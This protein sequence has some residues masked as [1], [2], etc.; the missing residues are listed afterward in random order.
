MLV[1]TTLMTMLYV[2]KLPNDRGQG[3]PRVRDGADGLYV[4]AYF[5]IVFTSADIRPRREARGPKRILR[6]KRKGCGN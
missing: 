6:P 1:A 3:V 2:S 5:G 4:S